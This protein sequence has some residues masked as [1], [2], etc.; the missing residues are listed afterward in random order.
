MAKHPLRKWLIV[1]SSLFLLA[2]VLSWKLR[3]GVEVTIQN[4]G[5]T[6][7]HSVILQ[8]T[9]A[10]YPLLGLETLAADSLFYLCQELGTPA[11]MRRAIRS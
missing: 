6:P 3:S 7:V 9:G 2:A 1:G 10:S 4:T 5:S 11:V 8:V